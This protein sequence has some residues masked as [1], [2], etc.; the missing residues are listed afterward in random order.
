MAG[1]AAHDLNSSRSPR[2]VFSRAIGLLRDGTFALAQGIQISESGMALVTPLPLAVD[3]RLVVT[4]VIP[5]GNGLVL[6]AHVV[7]E[8]DPVGKM[9]SYAIQFHALDLHER[10]MIRSYVSAK[11][12]A[13]AE[14]E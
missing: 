6:R 1:S 11:T 8:R 7:S 10:R 5:G 14:Q 12:Q 4:F 9:R 13:E 2:R 3:S